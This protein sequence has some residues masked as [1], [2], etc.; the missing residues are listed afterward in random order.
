MIVA[1]YNSMKNV[2]I[3]DDN[4]SERLILRGFLE[5][6]SY[7]VVAEGAS[8]DDALGIVRDK[9]PDVVIMDVKMPG[10]DG[11]EATAELI[12]QCP[13]PVVLLTAHDDD[14]TIVRGAKCGAMGYLVKPINCEDLKPVIEVAISRFAEFQNLRKENDSL[15]D[16]LDARK[17]TEKAKGLLMEKEGLSE[18]EA[19]ARIQKISM[20]KRQSMKEIA[21][22]LILALDSKSV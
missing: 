1:L 17:V 10:K 9:S 22:V 13:V 12:E 6:L 18:H 5:E 2:A 7:E 15:K 19:F 20:D 8:G 11:I 14:E 16:T 21:E 3:I 4:A